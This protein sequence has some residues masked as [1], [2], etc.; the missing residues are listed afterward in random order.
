MFL[1]NL[2]FKINA[3]FLFKRVHKHF[4]KRKTKIIII[5]KYGERAF[6]IL[7]ISLF[8]KKKSF[9]H[10]KFPNIDNINVLE[11]FL[12]NKHENQALVK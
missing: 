3:S 4:L 11:Y 1:V 2:L 12:L 6:V 7:G 8:W 10:T 5:Q 9:C